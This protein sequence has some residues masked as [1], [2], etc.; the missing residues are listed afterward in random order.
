MAGYS[1][2]PEALESAIK[3]LRDVHDDIRSVLQQADSVSP[4][5]LTAQD[6]Y[7]KRA[8]QIIQ[9]RATGSQGSLR[10]AAEELQENLENKITAYQETLDEYRRNEEQAEADVGRLDE[11]A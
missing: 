9:D 1:V 3:E 10:M 7:T 2:D 6:P 5:E 8:R 4:G 11:R